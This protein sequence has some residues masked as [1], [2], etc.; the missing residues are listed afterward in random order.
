M[1][2]NIITRPPGTIPFADTDRW[3]GGFGVQSDSRPDVLYTVS[4]D[5]AGG[6]WVCSCP[7]GIHRGACKHLTRYERR[8]TRADAQRAVE[9][10]EAESIRVAEEQKV[11]RQKLKG[12]PIR[13]VRASAEKVLNIGPRWSPDDP[14]PQFEPS[15]AGAAQPRIPGDLTIPVARRFR[16]PGEV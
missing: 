13:K 12:L 3:K 1:A 2:D 10:A 16:A 14:T 7:A 15:P 9:A 5:A 8:P 4:F 6:Y 11:A